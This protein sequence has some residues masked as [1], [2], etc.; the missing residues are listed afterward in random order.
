MACHNYNEI[1]VK[2]RKARIATIDTMLSIYLA[3]V[4]ADRTYYDMRRLLCMAEYMFEIQKQNRLS[5]KGV[6]KRFSLKCFGKQTTLESMRTDKATM[7]E[8]LKGKRNSKEWEE[9]FLRYLPGG[10]S[11]T[12]SKPTPKKTTRRRK[13]IARK[14]PRTHKKTRN[15]RNARNT[16]GTKKRKKRK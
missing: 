9:W 15:A 8:K 2:G 13:S 11:S 5:Q 16:Q 14:A 6:L 10:K 3:F 4:Y 12:D 7:F 1:S